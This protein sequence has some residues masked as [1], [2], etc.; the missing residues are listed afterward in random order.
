MLQMRDAHVDVPLTNISVSYAQDATNFVATRVF[1][2]IPVSKRSNLFF[3]YSKEDW[4]RDEARERGAGVESAGTEYNVD[5]E[6]YWCTRW[7]IHI[8]VTDEDKANYSEPLDAE[9]DATDYVTEKLLIRREMI[10]ATN[11]FTTGV[12]NTEYTGVT[13]N[14]TANQSFIQWDLD[15]STPIEDITNAIVYVASQTGRKPNTLV[16][17]PKVFNALRNNISI[18]DRIKYTERGII[19]EELIAS[20][21]GVANVYVMWGVVNSA[22]KNVE[23]NYDFIAGRNALLMY[24]E[25]NP[26]LRKP[27]AGYTFAWT[28][29]FGN[30]AMG[31]RIVRI[32]MDLLGLGTE[33]IEGE[34]YFDMKMIGNDL[35]VFFNEAVSEQVVGP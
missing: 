27:S 17:S 12:W 4:M 10:W 31:G 29:L 24:V 20:A 8:D 3:T 5:Q 15:T 18:L 28:G 6:T 7:S 19:T 34:M 22:D 25:P 23:G 21:I 14:P 35:A 1:P 11:F 2:I 16:I 26:G 30:S 32:P 13:A 33:R 9:I